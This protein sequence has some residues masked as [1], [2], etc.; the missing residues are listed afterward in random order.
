MKQKSQ[1][2]LML[3]RHQCNQ[4]S[5]LSN[6]FQSPENNLIEIIKCPQL[7]ETCKQRLLNMKKSWSTN[8][9]D[10][11]IFSAFFEHTIQTI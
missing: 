5:G 7:A 9:N 1:I 2:C 3:N 8:D 11:G 4:T 10:K 6:N